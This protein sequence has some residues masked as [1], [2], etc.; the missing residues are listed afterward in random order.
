M[1]ARLRIENYV[2][3]EH[4]ELDLHEG[5]TSM[6]GETGAGK[7]VILGALSLLL[8]Q[9]A[10]SSALPDSK[11][12]CVVEGEFGIE[13]LGLEDFFRTHEL[14][15]EHQTILRREILPQGKSRAFIN[16]TPVGLTVLREFAENMVDIHS[17]HRTLELN[18]AAFQMSVIDSL[19]RHQKEL[20]IYKDCYRDLKEKQKQLALLEAQEAQYQKDQDYF[21][22]QYQELESAGLES[23][24]LE[25]MEAELDVLNHASQIKELLAQSEDMLNSGEGDIL[26]R[27]A[28]LLQNLTQAARNDLRINDMVT[29]LQSTLIEL[30]ELSREIGLHADRIVLDPQRAEQL[31]ERI[32]LM[33][34]LMQKHQIHTLAD[35]VRLRDEI[36]EKLATMDSIEEEIR[37]CR[38]AVDQALEKA[39]KLA[40]SLTKSRQGV[41]PSAEKKL[42]NLL[43]QLGM[44]EAQLSISLN[45]A[46]ELTVNGKDRVQFLFSANKGSAPDVLSRVASG[47]E[48]SRLMLAVKSLITEENLLPTIIFDEIDSGVSG[49]VAARVGE[50]LADMSSRMQ[51]IAITHLPQI[52][53]RG[54]N[55]LY[56]Y[57]QSDHERTFTYIRE[58][59]GE[60]RIREI[61]GMI[62]GS[63]IS[64]HAMETAR[65]LLERS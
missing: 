36:G 40:D 7:S 14:D 18:E 28:I 35:L 13:G 37:K 23:V 26:T 41:L 56:V 29:R 43:K 9:R 59:A 31:S 24:S 8:G 61:A 38:I 51:V 63:S 27:T 46:D 4:L 34:R 22:F 65:E 58:L 16:D 47:G 33:N 50:I 1:L 62:S 60:E 25:E 5:L 39:W 20:K 2:L 49:E 10:D 30:K 42:R 53:A 12:K 55:H 54:R 19:A 57:K 32:D 3:I 45:T 52:A 6:T 11:R 64:E 44:P 15:Y 48:L 17:Q 21:Q